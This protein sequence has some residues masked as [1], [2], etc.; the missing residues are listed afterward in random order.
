[1]PVGGVGPVPVTM[2]GKFSDVD[3]L[4]NLDI[5]SITEN[6]DQTLGELFDIAYELDPNRAKYTQEGMVAAYVEFELIDNI[7]MTDLVPTID[8]AVNTAKSN[9][10]GTT[11]TELSSIP[12]T[13]ETNIREVMI[14]LIQAIIIVSIIVF[15]GLGLMNAI[16]V[17]ITVPLIILGTL[18]TIY[19]MGSELNIFS[20][21]GIILSIGILVD[22][23]IVIAESIQLKIDEGMDRKD[24][25]IKAVKGN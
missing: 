2:P 13:V 24:A 14:N 15:I 17:S 23:S 5:S 11:V 25:A 3:E 6:A 18:S 19:I 12:K 22:N 10:S 21:A 8:S 9:I 4:I 20:I 1:M 16:G 7:D